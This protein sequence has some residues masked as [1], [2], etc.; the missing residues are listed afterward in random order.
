[1]QKTC[2][3]TGQSFEVS[4]K[5]LAFLAEISP[6]F[7]GKTYSIP[8][9]TLCPEERERRRAAQVNELYL[10]KRKCDLSGKDILSNIH[11]SSPYKVYEQEDWYSDKWDPIDY[12]RDFDFS[13][14]FFDQYL[15][16]CKDVPHPNL[17]TGYQYD[18]NCDYTNYAGKNKNCYLIFDSDESWDCYFS[19]S[20]N[21]CKNCSDCYRARRCELCVQCIDCE[22]CYNS[23]YLQNCE[24]CTDSAFLENCIGCKNCLMCS[25]LRNKEYYVENKPVTP[26]QFEQYRQAL[27]SRQNVSAARERFTQ[28][29]LQHPHKYIHGIQNENVIG[30]YLTQCKD[31]DHCFDSERLWDCHYVYQAFMPLK[32]CLDIH[33]CGDGER[34][35]ECSVFG[36]GVNTA[37]FCANGLEQLSD[38]YYSTFCFH[39]SKLFGC[40]GLRHK[41]YC[42]FN[43][44][45]SPE[46]YEIL[47]GKIIE[48]MQSTGEWGEFFPMYTS[49]F[50]YNETLAQ[51]WHPLTKE[52]VQKLGLEWRDPDTKEYQPTN[53]QLPDNIKQA[54][55]SLCSGILACATCGKNYKLLKQELA[56]RKQMNVPLETQCF[57]C[58]N[59][60][61]RESR[62]P[63]VL[64]CRQ[65]IQCSK[66]LQTTFA[67]DRPEHI[68]CEQC[69]Q[70]AVV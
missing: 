59:K 55:E 18:E 69:Y 40:C 26:E 66:Q 39:G 2:S 58:S 34:M 52:Q 65:C 3:L 31:A 56:L 32:N 53:V 46:E 63:R 19:Y 12:G 24:N 27:G 36:Y 64:H 17:F 29:K 47:C 41:Q 60:D 21:G 44:Q 7:A 48:H 20:I 45:Y 33:E 16:L 68:L 50:A 62:N 61:R 51:D 15:E 22:G 6:T 28:L 57:H 70:Q 25:N 5:D 11:P 37:L 9:P 35:Y 23:M 49:P 38:M 14:P 1:M 4:D 54:D 10:Y 13:R 43:K 30:D 42:I 67:P 8:A